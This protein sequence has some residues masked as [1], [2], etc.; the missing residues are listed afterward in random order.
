MRARDTVERAALDCTVV[1]HA[2]SAGGG[3]R[4]P[5]L[6][7]ERPEALRRD[8]ARCC[9]LCGGAGAEKYSGLCDRRCGSAGVWTMRR[10]AACGLLWLD[11][12][13]A[14]EQLPRLY[15]NYY[16][17]QQGKSGS[18]TER[19]RESLRLALL[20]ANK[21][22]E[23][24]APSAWHGWIGRAAR[25]VPVARE[26]A[27]LGVMGLEALTTDNAPK[28][29]LLD[30]GSGSGRLLA[31][32]QRAGW[33]VAG[34]EPDPR[35]A[36]VA[37]ERYGVTVH[38]GHLEQARFREHSFDAVVLSH[39]IEHVEDPVALLAACRRLLR[40]GGRLALSTPNIE[41]RGLA[42][43]HRHWLHLDVPRHLHLFSARSL[44]AVLRGAG[45]SE[46]SIAS[47]AKSAASTWLSSAEAERGGPRR[48][49]DLTRA[50][51]FHLAESNAVR[52]GDRS[53]EEL[54]AWASGPG[55]RGPG[56]FAARRH[57]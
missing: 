56:G 25:F 29:R 36:A 34:V 48:F 51:A 45:F 15:Q 18:R 19:W 2:V 52:R 3:G 9:L 41:S 28:G 17:H 32:M 24:L 13:P 55:E 46:F 42:L 21:G 16:T 30:V 50:V 4:L 11:P 33:Q 20:S 10:C 1:E 53:G 22:Y 31:V 27:R 54:F 5:T 39:V 49:A 26:M 14:S 38:V 47:A 57:S 43:F 8:S 37:R 12:R 23:A 6:G 7:G 40:P 44:G 35:A